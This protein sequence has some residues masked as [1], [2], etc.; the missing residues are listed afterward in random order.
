M[1][2]YGVLNV[3][4]YDPTWSSNGL[5][6]KKY[7]GQTNMVAANYSPNGVGDFNN[8][9]WFR[10]AELKLLYAEALI[11]G[12]GDVSI[13]VQQIQDIRDRAGLTAPMNS[14]PLAAMMQEKRVEMAF[15]PHRWFDIVRWD[16]GPTIFG[17]SWDP[18]LE[19]FPF[20]LSEIDRSGGLMTQNAG[21]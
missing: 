10:F 16:L 2:P 15:E 20:P 17:S 18:K 6:L 13:A 11:R 1:S 12:G 9:R 5:S 3:L 8:E 4:D 19:V 7:R 21:Y 14:D